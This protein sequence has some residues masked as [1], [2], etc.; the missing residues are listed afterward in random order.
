MGRLLGHLPRLEWLLDFPRLL[1]HDFAAL[2]SSISHAYS[3]TSQRASRRI[4]CS[5]VE[6][7]DT[8]TS[9]SKV[10]AWD[11]STFIE[12]SEVEAWDTSTSEWRKQGNDQYFY[13]RQE[14]CSSQ[15]ASR[16]I[17]CSEVEGSEENSEEGC[18]SQ[19]ASR[20][21]ECSEVEGSEENSDEGK[22]GS[23]GEGKQSVEGCPRRTGRLVTPIER[24]LE[25]EGKKSEEG[26]PCRTGRLVAREEAAKQS[27]RQTDKENEGRV[28]TKG[29]TTRESGEECK[30]S[31]EAE[32][33]ILE[34]FNE[35]LQW[36]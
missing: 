36:W 26:C 14:G 2:Y 6:A 8:S 11:T 3:G 22:E 9:C 30:Q 10:K 5:E 17:E 16:R 32:G 15:R 4:E 7:W 12:C 21:I 13:W 24:A 20:R 25:G 28:S 33:W 19:R 31:I 1:W 27:G 35:V 23:E 29:I 18:S 34:Y